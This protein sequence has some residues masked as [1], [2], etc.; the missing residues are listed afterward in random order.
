MFGMV[1]EGPRGLGHVMGTGPNDDDDDVGNIEEYGV[2]WE[3]ANDTAIM[4][5]LLEH[6]PQERVTSQN[7]FASRNTPAELSDVPCEAPP[8]PLSPDQI[9]SLHTYLLHNFDLSSRNMLTRRGI[10][11]AA[12]SFSRTLFQN[13]L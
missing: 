7:P 12:L 9:H 10:W 4:A 3:A 8:S 2:D 13:D 1:R 11:E 6:N 5:H